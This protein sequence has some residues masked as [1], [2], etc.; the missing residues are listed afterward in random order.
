MPTINQLVRNGRKTPAYKGKSPDIREVALQFVDI[1]GIL[2]TLWVP[3][4][5]LPEVFEQGI[6]TVLVGL[7]DQQP[8]GAAL[9]QR[10]LGDQLRRKEIVEIVQRQ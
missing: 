5:D 3:P 1:E 7:H 8:A 10:S 6:H 9:G 4:G 2:H